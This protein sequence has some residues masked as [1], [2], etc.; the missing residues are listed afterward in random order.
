MAKDIQ[1]DLT[2]RRLEGENMQI[3]KDKD[4]PGVREAVGYLERHGIK[5]S[6]VKAVDMHARVGEPMEVTFTL[7]LTKEDLEPHGQAPNPDPVSRSV[8]VREEMDRA[9]AIMQPGD[10]VTLSNGAVI[11][12]SK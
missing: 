12:K 2:A 5:E 10:R 11:T 1:I 9:L 4:W 8:R 6:K 7:A 3:V